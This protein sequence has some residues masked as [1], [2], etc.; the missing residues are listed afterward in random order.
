MTLHTPKSPPKKSPK[1]TLE[2]GDEKGGRLVS[3][4]LGSLTGGNF[5]LGLKNKKKT[6][7]VSQKKSQG[8]Q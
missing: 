6:E 8:S 3:P 4:F 5:L 2:K 7:V 1:L